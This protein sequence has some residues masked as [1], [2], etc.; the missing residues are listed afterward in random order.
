MQE[1]NLNKYDVLKF[2]NKSEKLKY[3]NHNSNLYI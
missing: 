2:L 3:S 1:I